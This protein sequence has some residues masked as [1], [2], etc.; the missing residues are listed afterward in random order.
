MSYHSNDNVLHFCHTS[1]A[2]F[3]GGTVADYLATVVTW[4]NANPNEVLTLILT[5][6]ENV[7]LQNFWKPAFE[8][9]G[10]ASFAYVPPH[11]PM[12]QN[13]VR[14]L[15]LDPAHPL[16]CALCLTYILHPP[17]GRRSGS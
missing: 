10:V 4:L 7:S 16:S 9:S 2:L 13:E 15:P 12:R 17:S 11:L 14:L 5:N 8:Q 6:P 1:C 3:D